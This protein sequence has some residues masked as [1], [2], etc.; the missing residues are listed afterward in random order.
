MHKAIKTNNYEKVEELLSNSGTLIIN[1]ILKVGHGYTPVHASIAY[2]APEC[3]DI[4][5]K[6][7][8]NPCEPLNNGWYQHNALSLAIEKAC[9]NNNMKYFDEVYKFPNLS[10]APAIGELAKK[11]Y[12]NGTSK[13]LFMRILSHPNMVNT[14]ITNSIF[15][16]F[17]GTN[18]IDNVLVLL[19]KDKNEEIILEDNSIQ[20]AF[21]ESLKQNKQ[22]FYELFFEYGASVNDKGHSFNGYPIVISARKANYK[23][24]KYLLDNGADPNTCDTYDVTKELREITVLTSLIKSGKTETSIIKC[25][26]LLVNKGVNINTDVYVNH[27]TRNQKP[28]Q[29]A[30]LK[31]LPNVIKC[32][33]DNGAEVVQSDVLLLAKDNYYKK[34]QIIE[35]L[36]VM[37]KYGYDILYWSGNDNLLFNAIAEYQTY[38]CFAQDLLNVIYEKLEKLPMN[39]RKEYLLERKCLYFPDCYHASNNTKGIN[40][41]LFFSMQEPEINKK[42]TELLHE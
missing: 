12:N 9:I 23:M 32:L 40:N 27:W 39:E 3:F 36:K 42:L 15:E 24:M 5:I 25:F 34:T 1:E 30:I 22:Q 28:I 37:D 33:L 18:N 7:G 2:D 6:K 26:K 14:I 20:V 10:L 17:I 41:I 31:L 19:N 11:K 13:E 29:F 21:I 16:M 38:E 35:V 8:G 4:L